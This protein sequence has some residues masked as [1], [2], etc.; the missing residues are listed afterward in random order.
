MCDWCKV[1]TCKSCTTKHV[2]EAT[3]MDMRQFINELKDLAIDAVTPKEVE[4][5]ELQRNGACRILETLPD[6]V[7][8][9]LNQ[10]YKNIDDYYIKR[11][12]MLE[13]RNQTLGNEIKALNDKFIS[14]EIEYKTHI[15]NIGKEITESY[16][17]RIK[18]I[19]NVYS[20]REK[21][22]NSHIVALEETNN[23]LV[24]EIQALR[25][26]KPPST[27]TPKKKQTLKPKTTF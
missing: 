3:N 24:V 16:E 20:E 4:D 19:T 2:C 11:S 12:K 25:T 1:R 8:D 10:E 21:Q 17:K 22:L 13:E 5:Q 23:K 26:Q 15:T 27:L 18:D 6:I 9:H 7:I 14:L